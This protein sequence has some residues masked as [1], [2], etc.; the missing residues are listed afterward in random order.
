MFQNAVGGVRWTF[1]GNEV[2]RVKIIERGEG[3]DAGEGQQEVESSDEDVIGCKQAV[4]VFLG[5]NGSHQ[6]R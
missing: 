4:D 5:R 1:V 3:K 2:Q 6:R